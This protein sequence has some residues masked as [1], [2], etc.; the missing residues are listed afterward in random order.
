ME[1]MQGPAHFFPHLLQQ[2][3][4]F[5][6][7][8]AVFFEHAEALVPLTERTIAELIAASDCQTGLSRQTFWSAS[9]ILK[10]FRIFNCEQDLRTHP[11]VQ[12]TWL[13]RFVE[14]MHGIRKISTLCP[15]RRRK[16]FEPLLLDWK[17]S[18]KIA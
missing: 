5:E 14:L 8:P 3:V 16:S 15:D 4:D 17:T 6:E 11:A 12:Q 9:V 13:P 10:H 1:S 18:T 2:E 7:V